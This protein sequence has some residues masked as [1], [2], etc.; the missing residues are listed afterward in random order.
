[1]HKQAHIIAK[2]VMQKERGGRQGETHGERESAVEEEDEFIDTVVTVFVLWHGRLV[3]KNLI[4][5]KLP[6]ESAHPHF[7]TDKHVH[8]RTHELTLHPCTHALARKHACAN[9][10]Q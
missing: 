6:S 10:A 9:R 7:Y 1:M 8:T 4:Q 5:S 2:E 3:M